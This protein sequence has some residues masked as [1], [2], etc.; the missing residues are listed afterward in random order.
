M[1][2]RRARFTREKSITIGEM[3]SCSTRVDK[4]FIQ[5]CNWCA[6]ISR[7]SLHL[8]VH[9][10][11]VCH[12]CIAVAVRWHV[13]QNL[14]RSLFSLDRSACGYDPFPVL[15]P[16]WLTRGSF[17]RAGACSSAH[18]HMGFVYLGVISKF[19]H[20]CSVTR[21]ISCESNGGFC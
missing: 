16:P 10:P 6:N 21:V 2:S 3:Q 11:S 19:W 9:V 12:A 8:V 15:L 5:R 4:I 17:P 13:V 1:F 20:G 14:S 7:G 18:L